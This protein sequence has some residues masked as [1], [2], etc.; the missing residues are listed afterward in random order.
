[1]LALG[2]KIKD[3]QKITPLKKLKRNC[4]KNCPLG[5]PKIDVKI[6]FLFLATLIK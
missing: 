4:K 2:T 3:K 6:T 5:Y 1:V